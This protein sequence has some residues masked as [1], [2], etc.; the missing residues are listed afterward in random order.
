M[1][2]KV[3]LQDLPQRLDA[4]EA[5]AVAYPNELAEL[6]DAL[7]RGQPCLVECA[8]ELTPFL[9]VTLRLQLQSQ[10]IRCV[11]IDGRPAPDEKPLPLAPGLL[12]RMNA[13]LREAVRGPVEKRIV[14][15]PHLDLLA[16]G[17]IPLSAEAREAAAL[18]LENP[19]LVWLGFRDP[20]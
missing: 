6:V 16:G 19:E 15:L 10:G 18:L 17:P 20:T 7:R 3:A 13:A 8:K 14:V 5:V 1:S 4:A 12:G 9:F 11:Y 2:L